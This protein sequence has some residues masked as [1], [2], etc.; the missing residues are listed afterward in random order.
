MYVE[1]W[2]YKCALFSFQAIDPNTEAQ[3]LS[4]LDL[5]DAFFCIPMASEFQ[6]YFAF[7]WKRN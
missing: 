2:G 7:E 5:K 6:S 1:I 3:Y 4:L